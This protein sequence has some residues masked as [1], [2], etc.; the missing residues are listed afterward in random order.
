MS[1]TSGDPSVLVGLV[2]L[3]QT[4][5]SSR[6]RNWNWETVSIGL[7]CRQ[8]CGASSW[9]KI[10]WKDPDFCT[11][12]HQWASGFG[13]VYRRKRSKPGEASGVP[14]WPWLPRW[15]RVTCDSKMKST[16]SS[17]SCFW[18]QCRANSD[19][20]W[21]PTGYIVSLLRTPWVLPPHTYSS[22]II[23]SLFAHWDAGSRLLWPG[24]LLSQS[25]NQAAVRSP[26]LS[27]SFP[28][29]SS[30][31]RFHWAPKFT[32]KNTLRNGRLRCPNPGH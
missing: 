12:C 30:V 1:W 10:V 28:P 23:F 25:S 9:L 21:T 20:T 15:W 4:W 22:L 32:H 17:S 8:L 6:K 26:R 16:L 11:C 7:A 18:T 31:E 13:G 2:N 14:P 24:H 27:A 5:E 29:A 19:P 3:A